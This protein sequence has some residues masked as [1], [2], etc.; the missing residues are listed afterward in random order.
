MKKQFLLVCLGLIYSSNLTLM[1][2][3]VTDRDILSDPVAN[4]YLTE[5]TSE[6]ISTNLNFTDV[7][8]THW[9][10]EAITRLGALSVVKGYNEGNVLSYRPGGQVSNEEALAFLLRLIGQEEA[11]VIQAQTIASDPEDSTLTL[12]SRGYL[13]IASDNGLITAAQ[14][15]DGLTVDQSLLSEQFNWFRTDDVTREQVAMWLVQ[16]VNIAVPGSLTPINVH[17][18]I[19][20]LDDWEAISPEFLSYVE[21]VMAAGIMV[22]DGDSF[23]PKAPLTRAEMA[24]IMINMDEV[25]YAT[26][27]LTHKAG[28]VGSIKTSVS[29]DALGNEQSKTL[30]IRTSDGLV[31]QVT[32]VDSEDSLGRVD[33][34]DVPVLKNGQVAG[35][36]SLSE[37]DTIEYLVEISTNLV[38]YINAEGIDTKRLVSGKLQ[39]LDGLNQ[40]KITIEDKTGS[41][42]TYQ[43][44]DGIYDA[45]DQ[46]LELS[47][48]AYPVGA[49]PV[50]NTVTLT[51]QNDV[52]TYIAYDGAAPMSMEISGIVKEINTDFGFITIENW[53]GGETTKYYNKDVITVE[54]ENYYD[55]EDEIGYIDEVFPSYGFDERDAVIEAI[56]PG[57][58]VHMKLDPNNLQYVTGLSAKTNY[59]VKF[60]EITSLAD[61]G[62][63]GAVMRIAYE[64]QSL[65]A[66]TLSSDLPVML[67]GS[68]VG[69]HGLKVGQL[70]KVLLNQAV[71]GPG[72]TIETVKQVDIDAYGNIAMNLYKGEFGLYDE[73]KESVSL[74]NSYALNAEGWSDYEQMTSL[75]IS[76]NGLELYYEGKRVSMPYADKYL[77]QEDMMVYGVTENHFEDE[78]LARLIF[79]DGRG[80]VLA[81]TNVSY[82]N[83]YDTIKLVSSADA[84]AI[85]ASTIVIKDG[86]IVSTNSILSPDYAQVVLGDE[87]S[88]VMVHVTQEPNND[89][90]TILRGRID[91]IEDNQSFNVE[92]NAILKEME[93]VYSPVEREFTLSHDTIIVDEDGRQS[94][95]TFVDYSDFSKV[96]EVYTIIAKGT[97]ATHLYNN[98]YATEGVIGTI[99]DQDDTQLYI[100][101]AFVYASDTK[102]WSTLSLTDNYAEIAL[103]AETVIIKNNTV[104]DESDL[105]KGDK[106]R[107]LVTEKLAEEVKINNNRVV[108]GYII[109]VE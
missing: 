23:N 21:A 50:T 48:V 107:V 35:L 60:G 108:S 45:S 17:Q 1:S 84:I 20:T 13:Q 8:E 78:K 100:K 28:V 27:G 92:S 18:E 55:T 53:H 67:K 2:L 34:L 94:L 42:V 14:L 85:D 73:A 95:E 11:A 59:S 61:N 102:L 10:K 93:W 7:A 9:A 57:D 83:G 64:D 6:A 62:A 40:G 87:G 39:P 82:S 54:K 91:S 88:A 76:N 16:V 65:G 106:I 44:S 36:G 26:M 30:L 70:V 69:T 72:Q 24:Q 4:V 29:V 63:Q 32:L 109:F 75:E 104:I 80:D 66:L 25:L 37:G 38:K 97:E 71:L 86:H 3:A 47:N 41:K 77:R 101:D 49:A 58:I 103:Q 96:D 99:Y 68:N 19:F 105:K 74:L 90:M 51:V 89:A 56:D 33:T 15:A 98:I 31:D 81:S 5:Q 79:E 43:M 22:G 46:T 52:V 12:W